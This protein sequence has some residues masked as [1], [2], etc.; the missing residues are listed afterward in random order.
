MML[1]CKAVS[2]IVHWLCG[3]VFLTLPCS[4][5]MQPCISTLCDLIVSQLL[6]KNCSLSKHLCAFAFGHH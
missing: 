1:P 5:A 4:M 2:G 3:K 6:A